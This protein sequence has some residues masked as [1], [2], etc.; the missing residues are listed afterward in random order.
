MVRRGHGEHSLT[1]ELVFIV[2]EWIV[3]AGKQQLT[4]SVLKRH[5]P[6]VRLLGMTSPGVSVQ[7]MGNVAAAG[8]Q[9]PFV[10]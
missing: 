6:I 5:G 10:P 8:D 2:N 3:F 4:N 1:A 9:N 7:V